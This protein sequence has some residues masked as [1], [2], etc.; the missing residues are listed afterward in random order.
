[1][2]PVMAVATTIGSATSNSPLALPSSMIATMG[3]STPRSI[4]IIT[5]P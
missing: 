1:M 3:A 2:P 4:S 5:G